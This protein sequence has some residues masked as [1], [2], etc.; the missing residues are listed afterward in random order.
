MGYQTTKQELSPSVVGGVWNERLKAK[1]INKELRSQQ[2]KLKTEYKQQKKNFKISAGLIVFSILLIFVG[3]F[4]GFPSLIVFAFIGIIT[5]IIMVI[6]FYVKSQNT[7]IKARRYGVL[8]ILTDKLKGECS[9]VDAYIN[10][11]NPTKTQPYK[12]ARSPYSGAFKKYY[13]LFWLRFDTNLLDGTKFLISA[14]QKVK[15][16][17]GGK[18]REITTFSFK[19]SFSAKGKD[20]NLL[21]SN[22]LVQLEEL[23]VNRI[24]NNFSNVFTSA[25]TSEYSGGR[26]KIEYPSNEVLRFKLKIWGYTSDLKPSGISKLVSLFNTILRQSYFE[27]TKRSLYPLKGVKLSPQTVVEKINR[28]H[29][30]DAVATLKPH[31]WETPETIP[32]EAFI[33][34]AD[35]VAEPEV[36]EVG[37]VTSKPI[38]VNLTFEEEK[39][40]DRLDLYLGN[41]TTSISEDGEPYL[42]FTPSFGDYSEIAVGIRRDSLVWTAISKFSIKKSLDLEIIVDLTV[43]PKN[44]ETKYSASS[45]KLATSPA[46]NF[47]VGLAL[48]E[49]KTL[50]R[51]RIHCNKKKNP[52]IFVEVGRDKPVNI[53]KAYE[54]IRNLA[55]D[56]R[57]ARYE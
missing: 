57:Y 33:I 25:G 32:Q 11:G 15:T 46:S 45:A 5:A 13:Y 1:Y 8:G 28:S 23:V 26:V 41:P 53:Y 48:R 36:S 37:E 14:H 30:V 38:A 7:K 2:R 9:T 27:Q 51:I 56:V 4:A 52:I 35:E 42:S 47:S 3:A 16:K 22:E 6:V 17:S 40:F 55:S 31:E 21:N 39:Q 50:K 10:Y 19:F 20:Y 54:L 34:E 18:V 44:W 49:L 24:R 12:T 43:E 29:S